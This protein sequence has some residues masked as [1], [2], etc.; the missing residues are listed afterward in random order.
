M[1]FDKVNQTGCITNT[2]YSIERQC[3][4]NSIQWN[5]VQRYKWNTWYN[6]K[7]LPVLMKSTC[8][9][10]NLLTS[11]I[12]SPKD[13]IIKSFYCTLNLIKLHIP[14]WFCPSPWCCRTW[15]PAQPAIPLPLPSHIACIPVPQR[16][17]QQLHDFHYTVEPCY[18]QFQWNHYLY[19]INTVNCLSRIHWDWWNSFHLQKI[20]LM[21]GKKKKRI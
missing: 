17:R 8:F 21:W 3:L 10:L 13:L 5:K 18:N 6:K 15:V 7:K 1:K 2:Q 12:H 4:I 19:N 20:W 14:V 16:R 9:V 11:D